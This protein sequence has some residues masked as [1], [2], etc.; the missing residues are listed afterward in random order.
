MRRAMNLLTKYADPWFGAAICAM[1]L[2][3]LIYVGV[4]EHYDQQANR[5]VCPGRYIQ[6]GRFRDSGLCIKRDGLLW[7]RRGSN[8]WLEPRSTLPHR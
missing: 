3:A 2:C 1:M 8:S 7:E 5:R 6:T 4:M